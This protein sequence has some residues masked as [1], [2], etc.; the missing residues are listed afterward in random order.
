MEYRHVRG[1][2][3]QSARRFFAT[4]YD[5]GWRIA[6]VTNHCVVS[7][8]RSDTGSMTVDEVAIQGRM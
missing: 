6:G 1:A 8:R 7:H 4:A 5:P 2:D 3:A